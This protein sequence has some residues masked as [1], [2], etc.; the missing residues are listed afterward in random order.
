MI[1]KQKIKLMIKEL[2]YKHNYDIK[3]VD[4][5]EIRNDL[6]TYDKLYG[7]KAV[8]ERRFYNIGAGCFR[9]D[10]W[11][12]IDKESEW[13]ETATRNNPNMITLDLFDSKPFPIK[14]ETAKVIYS[15][16]LIEHITN[17]ATQKMLSESYRILGIVLRETYGL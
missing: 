7:E 17:E 10:A 14:S 2:A 5:F 13:Y 8:K 4:Q 15:S 6:R 3:T 11:T 1:N 9:H 12:N 16:H